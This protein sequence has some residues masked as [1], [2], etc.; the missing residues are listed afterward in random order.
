MTTVAA[1]ATLGFTDLDEEVVLDDLDVTGELPAWLG[2]SL[3]RTGPARWDLGE[4]TVSHWFDGLAMLHRFTIAS[5]RVSYANRFLRSKAFEAAQGGKLGFSEFATDP[6]RSAFRRVASLFDPALTDN[7]AVNVA[8]VM[9]KWV[10]LTETPLPVAFDPETLETLGVVDPPPVTIGLAHPHGDGAT[11]ISVGV[12]LKGRPAYRV[13]ADNRVVAN[14]PVSR[15]GYIHSFAMTERF[16]VITEHPFSVNP[17]KLALG[18]RPF[19]ENYRWDPEQGT[20]FIVIDRRTGEH[21]GDWRTDAFFTFH[22]VNAFEDGDDIVTDLLAY[23]DP[24]IIPALGLARMRAG[25]PV[26]AAHL[27]RFRLLPGGAVEDSRLSDM[28][29]ELP[30]IDYGRVNGRPYRY[31]WGGSA[32]GTFYD[33]IVKID[34]TTGEHLSWSEGF[35]GEPVFVGRPGR[36]EEDDGVLLTVVLEPERGASS[37]VVLDAATLQLRARAGVPHHVPFGFHGQFARA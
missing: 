27:R 31:V 2:G 9:G 23:A 21:V 33:T 8:R 35:P 14:I 17:L 11:A 30:R 37:L 29:I 10:A 5:G 15:P 13:T 22:H 1:D 20:R 4:Q 3:L 6:C 19:I 12:H 34:V 7:G 24:E 28:P 36:T 32:Q 16:A 26:P 18:N 25:E